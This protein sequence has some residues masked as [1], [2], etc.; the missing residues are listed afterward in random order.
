MLTILLSLFLAC[1]AEQRCDMLDRAKDCAD[2]ALRAE[3]GADGAK[4]DAKAKKLYTH[5]CDLKD[6][7]SCLR[8]GVDAEKGGD[9]TGAAAFYQKA[10]GLGV[11]QGC[12]QLALLHQEGALD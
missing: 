9:A 12:G 3:V 6:G 5:A 11:G 10:C 2:A 8:L 1:T 7:D 4:D